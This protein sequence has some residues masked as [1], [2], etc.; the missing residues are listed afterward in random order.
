[1]EPVGKHLIET[2]VCEHRMYGGVRGR[3]P[4]GPSY[5]IRPYLPMRAKLRVPL[6]DFIVLAL[7]K[8]LYSLCVIYGLAALNA[9]SFEN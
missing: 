1:M 5:S 7:K 6:R 4:Q 9:G 8:R 2:A 3:G